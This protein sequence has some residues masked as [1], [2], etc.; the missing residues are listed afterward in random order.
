MT[1]AGGP[2]ILAADA[3]QSHGLDVVELT[4]GNQGRAAPAAA[5][6]RSR[7]QSGRHA[8]VGPAGALRAA[9]DL[10]LADPNVDSVLVIFIPPLVTDADE[11]A[12]AIARAAGR[13]ATSRS[14]ASSCAATTRLRRC[15]TIPCFAFPEPAAIA[16]AA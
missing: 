4:R 12:A 16:M 10:V 7:Q 2:G 14:P 11:V 5:R 15:R 6:R 13:A 1:N 3:C 8:G 9:L